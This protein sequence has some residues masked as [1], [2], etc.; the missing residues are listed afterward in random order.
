ME[1]QLTSSSRSHL[2]FLFCFGNFHIPHLGSP[3]RAMN[4]E[5][6]F[7]HR[8][9]GRAFS[10][11]PSE[12]GVVYGRY[13]PCTQPTLLD[14]YIPYG[15]CTHQGSPMGFSESLPQIS[16][17]GLLSLLLQ[18]FLLPSFPGLLQCILGPVLLA[19]CFVPPHFLCWSSAYTGFFHDT[20]SGHSHGFLTSSHWHIPANGS[21]STC[22]SDAIMTWEGPSEARPQVR[23]LRWQ[24]NLPWGNSVEVARRVTVGRGL[25]H[26]PSQWL[27]RA[28]HYPKSFQTRLDSESHPRSSHLLARSD[29]SYG[30]GK[31]GKAP[32]TQDKDHSSVWEALPHPGSSL[33]WP[34]FSVS[35]PQNLA[36]S[37]IQEAPHHE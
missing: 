32:Q 4:P 11:I 17:R 5:G 28:T 2:T 10:G 8:A 18:R 16:P 26:Q 31:K 27:L 22:L 15:L 14:P 7:C 20:P 9:G 25:H 29:F 30:R 13:L 19:C 35:P 3:S 24:M 23:M 12:L 34:P 36:G 6:S 21:S 1:L 33:N 37:P